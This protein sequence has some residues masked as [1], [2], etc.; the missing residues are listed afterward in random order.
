MVAAA[1]GDTF[2]GEGVAQ[3]T[4]RVAWADTYHPGVGGVEELVMMDMNL[5]EGMGQDNDEIPRTFE[6]EGHHDGDVGVFEE[7]GHHDGDVGV[8]DDRV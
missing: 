8:D 1:A 4:Y 2:Q 3:D 6:E 5:V 7:E